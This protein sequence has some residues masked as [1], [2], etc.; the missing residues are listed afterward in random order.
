MT[1]CFRDE[2]KDEQQRE[3]LLKNSPTLTMMAKPSAADLSALTKLDLPNLG[4][5]E[6]PSCLPKICPSLSILFCPKNKFVEVPSL[7]G[8]CANLQMVSFKECQTIESIHPEALQPQLRW[9]ILT[10]NRISAI[11]DTI[12]RCRKLQKFMLSGNR[13]SELPSSKIWSELKNLELI[14]L[15]CNQ[16]AEPPMELLESCTNL[17]WA[18]FA[19]NPFLL[20]AAESSGG[21]DNSNHL[22]LPVLDD[23]VLDDDSWPELGRGAGG[24]TRRVPWKGRDVAVKTFSGELT[25]DGSPQ[26]EKAISKLVTTTA[27]T[28]PSDDGARKLARTTEPALIELL[29]ETKTGGALVM[30]FLEGYSALAGPPSFETCSRDVYSDSN[31]AALKGFPLWKIATDT[32]RVLSKL[33]GLQV[34]HADFYAHNIL[35]QPDTH[36]VKVSD[37]GA[38]FR[39]R[40]DAGDADADKFGSLVETVEL[41]AYAVLVEELHG[42][43]A[44]SEDRENTEH[45]WKELLEE[46]RKPGATFR[47]LSRKFL[48]KPEEER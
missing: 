23:P 38:A 26:D 46:C 33:H 8:K 18:A 1:E 29:G 40:C 16:L 24:V 45:P 34:S 19:G 28:T 37:F 42:L 14:R 7:I 4:L 11:P 5:T 48:S 13:I 35:I 3:W 31:K 9:L 20:A 10:G 12:G 22:S 25:S 15:A 32:L 43:S 27:T 44:T 2:T 41:R 36:S 30:E 17:R 6:L 39:Y 47:G 21:D